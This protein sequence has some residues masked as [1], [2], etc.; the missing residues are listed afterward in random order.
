MDVMAEREMNTAD[1]RRVKIATKLVGASVRQHRNKG[2]FRSKRNWEVE[3]GSC[4]SCEV[5]RRFILPS[6]RA[7]AKRDQIPYIIDDIDH[8]RE[9]L[10]QTA[11]QALHLQ[12]EDRPHMQDQALKLV[13]GH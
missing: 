10:H 2:L 3:C 8:H 1:K 12:E 5:H 7:A 11:K 6:P 4:T 9:W 13:V